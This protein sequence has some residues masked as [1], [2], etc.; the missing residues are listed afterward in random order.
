MNSIY[1]FSMFTNI[2]GVEMQV[3]FIPKLKTYSLSN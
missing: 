2:N 3:S 1:D